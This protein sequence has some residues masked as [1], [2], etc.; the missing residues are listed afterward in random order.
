MPFILS[1]LGGLL[2]VTLLILFLVKST[3]IQNVVHCPAHTWTTIVHNFG[4]GMSRDIRV[5]IKAKDNSPVQGQYIEQKFLWIFPQAPIEGT[6][7]NEMSFHREWINARYILK[8]QP[9]CDVEVK[10]V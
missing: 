4:T 5:T 1:A 10:I 3:R 9:S 2:G 8:I 7:D 6:L